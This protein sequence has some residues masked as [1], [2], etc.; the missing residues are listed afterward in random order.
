MRDIVET[1]GLHNGSYKVGIRLNA[2]NSILF[3]ARHQNTPS[4]LNTF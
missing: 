2:Y 3:R 1:L 4:L